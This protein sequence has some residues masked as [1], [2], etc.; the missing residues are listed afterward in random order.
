[1]GPLESCS[2]LA[3]EIGVGIAAGHTEMTSQ[4]VVRMI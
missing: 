1:M 2:L 4:N 3:E